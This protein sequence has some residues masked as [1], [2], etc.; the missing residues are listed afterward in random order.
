M[1]PLIRLIYASRS[2]GMAMQHAIN[3]RRVAEKH[4]ESAGI[5][6]ALV[7]TKQR[8]M[9]VLEGP[10]DAV[11]SLLSRIEKDS[12]HEACTVLLDAE[13]DYR[14]WPEWSMK[15]LSDTQFERRAQSYGLEIDNLPEDLT[16]ASYWI[17]LLYTFSVEN[18]NS[19]V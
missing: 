15:L 4:N 2:R 8:F 19:D 12:R 13:I 10:D 5:T 18:R 3:I 1:K 11:R 7:A 17:D 16:Q 9:Q 6:G 14:L